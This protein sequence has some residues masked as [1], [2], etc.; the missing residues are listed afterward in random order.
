MT[1]AVENTFCRC[2]NELLASENV[3]YLLIAPAK[4]VE[5]IENIPTKPPTTLYMP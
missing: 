3:M 2:C 4:D 5:T 1:I